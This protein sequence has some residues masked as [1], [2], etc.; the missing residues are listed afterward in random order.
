MI[1][2]HLFYSD[3]KDPQI[4]QVVV[5]N[6]QEKEPFVPKQSQSITENEYAPPPYGAKS[7]STA[8]SQREY[9]A[10]EDATD[11][12]IKKE[13]EIRLKMSAQNMKNLDKNE[14]ETQRSL[15][16]R[17]NNSNE[18]ISTGHKSNVRQLSKDESASSQPQTR[19]RKSS[20]ET[21]PQE[22]DETLR[23]ISRE[24][25]QKHEPKILKEIRPQ[26]TEDIVRRTSK[27]N[28]RVNTV[29]QMS[30][31]KPSPPG[32]Q[33]RRQKSQ[34]ASENAGI[35]SPSF[36]ARNSSRNESEAPGGRRSSR[37]NDAE[38]GLAAARSP[39]QITRSPSKDE[40]SSQQPGF[41]RPA[42]KSSNE[43]KAS[44][45]QSKERPLANLQKSVSEEKRAAKENET[46][47]E[48]GMQSLGKLF[49]IYLGCRRVD[50]YPT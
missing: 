49:C 20:N 19:G 12:S 14:S 8:A 31:E 7:D 25:A 22:F 21:R 41:Q 32:Q 6:K 48:A 5:E 30:Q 3:V 27:D 24:E 4:S 47:D 39:K 42:S 10:D 16:R 40:S 36:D 9:I 11:G 38:S 43:F 15:A 44:G 50:L 35:P 17:P 37:K 2:C 33:T 46:K 34:N 45:S 28:E 23:E 29:R 18:N 13:S 26:P 1:S